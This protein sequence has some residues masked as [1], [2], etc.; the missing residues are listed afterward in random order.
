MANKHLKI[1]G[2][3]LIKRNITLLLK[4]YYLILIEH[5]LNELQVDLLQVI[6]DLRN[7]IQ[8]LPIN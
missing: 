3:G 5:V 4:R 7:T 6:K 8:T 1:T 2:L